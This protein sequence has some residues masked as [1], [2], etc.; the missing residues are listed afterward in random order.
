MAK[1]RVFVTCKNDDLVHVETLRAWDVDGEYEFVHE[2]ALPRVGIHT[3]DG[4]LMKNEL[5]DKIKACSH[6]LCIIGKLAGDNDW[7]NWEVQTA[8]VTGRKVIAVRLQMGFKSPAAL[9]NFGAT[10]AKGFTF[11]AI[12]TAI[13]VGESSAKPAAELTEGQLDPHGFG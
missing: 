8:S 6:F 11:D 5:T 1:T 2:S 10:W 4:K 7:I 13:A 9:L 12:K 3:P